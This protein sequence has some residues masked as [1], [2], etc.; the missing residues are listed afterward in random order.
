MR[1]GNSSNWSR[2]PGPPGAAAE[3]RR[4]CPRLSAVAAAAILLMS[5]CSQ[6]PT[7]AV[8]PAHPRS[9]AASSSKTPLIARSADPEVRAAQESLAALGYYRDPIDGIDGP[10]TR[11]AVAKYQTDQ[12]I[13]PD[14][15]VS[16]D[17]VVQLAGARPAPIERDRIDR[18]A[19]PLYEPG[20][21]YIYTD[22]Q[23]E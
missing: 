11:A 19:G 2:H 1:I 9:P 14:G 4:G 15:R 17:L 22:G 5:G 12:G 10:Q 21:V 20:D 6:L 3:M 16:R 8:G 7:N 18:A 23:I 13:P